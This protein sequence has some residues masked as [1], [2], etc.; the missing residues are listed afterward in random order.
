P[1]PYL[2]TAVINGC[3]TWGRRQALERERRPPPPAP[4][5]LHAD[6]LWDALAKLNERQRAAIVLRF[7]ADLP[8]TEIA[9]ALGCRVP[10]VRTAIHRGLRAL[11]KEIDR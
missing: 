7:Y 11:R 8:D 6:E 2:R 1:L 3:R 10:T 4:A 9:Q 5:E